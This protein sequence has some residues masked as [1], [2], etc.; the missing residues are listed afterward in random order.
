M[1]RRK[2]YSIIFRPSILQFWLSGF[3]M[4]SLFC[5]DVFVSYNTQSLSRDMFFFSLL[6]FPFSHNVFALFI[7]VSIPSFFFSIFGF[8]R[9][10]RLVSVTSSPVTNHVFGS[11]FI[12]S[13]ILSFVP[14]KKTWFWE[15]SKTFNTEIPLHSTCD[16]LSLSAVPFRLALIVVIERCWG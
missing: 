13:F 14:G 9:S 2:L 5:I 11:V 1:N 10:S 12:H 16:L 15:E 6:P 4:Y 7:S 8:L 3:Q